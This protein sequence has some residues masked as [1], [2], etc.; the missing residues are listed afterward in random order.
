M[1][2]ENVLSV[3]ST[4]PVLQSISQLGTCAVTECLYTSIRRKRREMA[5]S[6]D[7]LFPGAN[8]QH[9]LTTIINNVILIIV[10]Y[11][12]HIYIIISHKNNNLRSV[13]RIKTVRAFRNNTTVLLTTTVCVFLFDCL[14]TVCMFQV[15]DIV[16][17]TRKCFGITVFF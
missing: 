10:C 13:G 8:I 5:K 7:L 16:T 15:P 17:K 2:R 1:S 6:A 14:M 12:F 9:T 3:S 11:L 4:V